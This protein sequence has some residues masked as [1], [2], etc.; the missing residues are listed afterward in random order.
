MRYALSKLIL[1]NSFVSLNI[2]M[3]KIHFDKSIKRKKRRS[4]FWIQHCVFDDKSLN[5]SDKV[6]YQSLCRFVNNETQECFPSMQT[7]VDYTGLSDNT[8]RSR[9]KHLKEL[10]YIEIDAIPGKVNYYQINEPPQ[11]LNPRKMLP[12]TPANRS[13]LPPQIVGTNNNNTNNNKL[14]ISFDKFW[15]LYDKKVGKKSKIEKK[16]NKLSDK[17]RKNIISY[18]P[19]YKEAQPNKKY[20]KNPETFLNN[21][22]WNDEII[23][24]KKAKVKKPYFQGTPMWYDKSKEKWFVIS[25]G[26]FLEFVGD[27]KDIK[28]KY[29]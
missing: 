20:R 19:K 7:L 2:N 23:S 22:S 5:P 24:D 9:L 17:D 6:V 25:D 28:W 12:T 27:E 21:E 4:F 1:N 29:K 10:G 11:K 8:I 14:T 26:T 3:R 16:W 18:L 15:N 13:P